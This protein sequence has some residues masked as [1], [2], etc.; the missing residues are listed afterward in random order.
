MIDFSTVKA[1]FLD[2]GGVLINLDKQ[3]CIENLHNITGCDFSDM[4]SHYRQAGIFLQFEKGLA[5]EQEFCAEIRKVSKYPVT[6]EQ[7]RVAWASFLLDVPEG[8]KQLLLALHKQFKV[9]MLSNTNVIHV[10][11]GM[12]R[13]FDTDGYSR[14]DYFDKCYFSNEIHLAKPEPAIFDYVLKD[15]GFL[16][17]ECLFLDDGEMNI[18]MASRM[19]F[20]TY[21]V[22]PY[23]DL[24]P[25][26]ASVLNG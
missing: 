5:T 23:E 1:L 16:P 13:N 18:E 4:V 9:F 25:L 11:D 3:R 2:F 8:K 10:T 6:D 14:H 22:K 17:E 20:Q 12:S 24:V 19:G 7:I 21:L 15:S 26:F